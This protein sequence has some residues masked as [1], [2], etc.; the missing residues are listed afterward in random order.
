MTRTLDSHNR[1]MY[2]PGNTTTMIA[3]AEATPVG[4]HIAGL[5]VHIPG[6]ARDLVFELLAGS[7]HQ[8]VHIPGCTTRDYAHKGLDSTLECQGGHIR[9][10]AKFER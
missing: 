5:S 8:S 2:S 9:A 10:P 3:E 6:L 7:E 1:S 4:V